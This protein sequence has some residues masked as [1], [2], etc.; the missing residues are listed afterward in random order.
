MFKK[1]INLTDA[2]DAGF[3]GLTVAGSFIFCHATKEF[4][5]KD[6]TKTDGTVVKAI[7]P[8]KWW[9]NLVV[10]GVGLVG[11]MF[12]TNAY[13][14][15]ACITIFGFFF[16]RTLNLVTDQ[17]KGIQ[18]LGGVKEFLEKY[19]PNLKG[20]EGSYASPL[21]GITIGNAQDLP[22][23]SEMEMLGPGTL[24]ILPFPVR[25]ANTTEAE[26]SGNMYS[27]SRA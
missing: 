19:V 2:K 3:Q 15:L 7:I 22:P 13:A 18:G 10:A 23:I 12:A 20:I 6:R 1:S 16:L 14:K 27:A 26:R 11:A 25:N 4:L 8:D 9:V 21:P 17:L 5:M 24:P